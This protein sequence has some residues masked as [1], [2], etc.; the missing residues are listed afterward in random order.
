[1]SIPNIAF[2]LDSAP[3]TWSS[4][5]DRHLAICRALADRGSR[6]VLVFASELPASIQQRFTQAGVSIATINYSKGPGHYYK[7]LRKLIAENSI[8]C[9]HIIFFDYFRAI[10]WLSKLSGVKSVIYEMQ[11][12]GVFKAKSWKR[13][14]IHARNRLMTAP[15]VRVIAIS[16]FI[17]GQLVE[18]GVPK[19]K[20]VVRHLGIDTDRFRP[21]PLQRDQ[22]LQRYSIRPDEVLLSTVSYLRPIKSPEII[23][24]AIGVLAERNVSVRLFVGGDGEMLEELQ[25]LS[26]DLGVEDRIHWLGLVP[27]PLDLLQASDIFL[28]ATVGEAFGLVLA[29]SMACGVPVVGSRAGAIPEVVEDGVTGVLVTPRDPVTLADGIEKL[30]KDKS[31]CQQMSRAAVARVHEK[32]TMDRAVLET[33][34]VYESLN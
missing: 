17:K 31:L 34:R 8:E 15:Y 22:L 1:M 11:N 3:R 24:R 6:A 13:R 23:V 28:L 20:I 10:G 9:V 29:E 14:L 2:L 30:V 5:E 25:Q 26:A 12:G 16:D 21:Q 32:F 33:L 18:G 19:E 27:D 4:Q 7:E